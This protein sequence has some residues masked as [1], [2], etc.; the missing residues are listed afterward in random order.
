MELNEN[1]FRKKRFSSNVLDFLCNLNNIKNF[2]QL[3]KLVEWMVIMLEEEKDDDFLGGGEIG[4]TYFMIS[5]LSNNLEVTTEFRET[6][7]CEGGIYP[8]SGNNFG[9]GYL[10]ENYQ[11]FVGG[12]GV[13]EMVPQID[14]AHHYGSSTTH[15]WLQLMNPGGVAATGKTS[16]NSTLASRD[17]RIKVT[18]TPNQTFKI[19]NFEDGQWVMWYNSLDLSL[20]YATPYLLTGSPAIAGVQIVS[21]LQIYMRFTYQIL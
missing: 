9:F 11:A 6:A 13:A 8:A 17:C 19:E 15:T 5:A 1:G 16:P 18:I 3:K 4:G 20:Y 7:K 12:N 2:S 10:R 21:G 14:F